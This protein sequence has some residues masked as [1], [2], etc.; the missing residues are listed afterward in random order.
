[1]AVK[2]YIDNANDPRAVRQ[3]DTFR[4]PIGEYELVQM[5]LL[6]LSNNTQASYRLRNKVLEFLEKLDPDHYGDNQDILWRISLA[7]GI[8][9]AVIKGGAKVLPAIEA[10][11]LEDTE[12]VDYHASFFDSYRNDVGHSAGG[13]IVGNELA[14]EDI[15]FVDNFVS[16]RLRFSHLWTAR[17]TLREIADRIDADDLG[18]ISVFNENT[19]IVMERLVN[20]MRHSRVL[21]SQESMDFMTGDN[22]FEA[23]IRATIA[24]RNK[25]QSVVKTGVGMFNEM[26]GGGYEGSRVY[27]HF[28]RSGDWKSGWLCSAAFWA[29][30]A[31]FNPEFVTKDPT[32]KPCVLFVTMEND[33]FDTIERMV[34]FALGSDTDLRGCDADQVVRLLEESFSSETCRFVFK[35]RQSRSI[36]TGDLDTMIHD[37]YLRGNEVV[38]VV[39]DYIKRI[40]PM[41][42]TKDARHLELG[43][44]VDDLSG[45]AKKH[46]IPV[47]TGMQLNRGAYEKFE[48]AIERNDFEAIKKFGASDVGESINVYENADVVIFQG[49][50]AMESTNSLWLTMRRAKMR[51]KRTVGLDFMNQPFDRDDNGDI[52]EMRLCEDADGPKS[53]WKGVKAIVDSLPR[54]YNADNPGTPPPQQTDRSDR[55]QSRSGSLARRPAVSNPAPLSPAEQST[56]MDQ[57]N[58]NRRPP[59]RQAPSSNAGRGTFANDLSDF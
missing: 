41:E 13:V 55:R 3:P 44:V 47:V 36:T 34:S 24:S 26:I 14:D 42:L 17:D 58:D 23:A 52:N 37:E 19:G 28:G 54:D 16:T 51:G 11:V 29:A 33:L 45:L 56:R 49:R 10:R 22:S 4:F 48:S 21:L 38:M 31:R 30:D 32:R 59:A 15:A 18:D 27:V 43:N 8:G 57:E 50:V 5:A 53:K 7:K 39:Q 25:P 40:K 20:K 9:K 6:F 2:S 12:W 46:N 35:Y 1:M